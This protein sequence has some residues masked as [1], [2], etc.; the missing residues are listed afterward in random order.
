M[1]ALPN[2]MDI[3]IPDYGYK[4]R[5]IHDR[6]SSSQDVALSEVDAPTLSVIESMTL[7]TSSPE[8]LLL[9]DY[10]RLRVGPREDA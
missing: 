2:A 9:L 6:R 8:H 3:R 5:V 10:A 1:P 4:R 7:V